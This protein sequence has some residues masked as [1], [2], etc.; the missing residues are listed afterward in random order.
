MI[1]T[2]GA[3]LLSNVTVTLPDEIQVRGAE[4]TL[5][6]IATIDGED[7]AAVARLKEYSLGYA[8]SPGYSRVVQRWKLEQGVQREFPGVQIDFEGKA[9]CRIWPSVT[10]IPKAELETAAHD[11][12][13]AVFEGADVEIHL[14]AELHDETVPVGLQSRALVAEPTTTAIKPGT[15]AVPVKVL[16]DGMPYRTVWTSFRVDLYGVV[17]V[18]NRDVPAGGEIQLSDVVMQRAPIDTAA[19]L[20]PLDGSKLTG[21]KARRLLRAGM[22]VGE[23]D[24]IRRLAVSRGETVT[25]VVNN[26]LVK[27]CTEVVALRDGYVGDLIPVQTFGRGKELTAKAVHIGQLELNLNRTN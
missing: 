5:G 18:L 11:A 23:A 8:P 6:E 21:A 19:S 22:P 16:I 7:L 9:A 27:V 15:W 20:R 4:M 25:L 14:A 24:V 1:T 26:G 10:K 13:V 3:L 17:P 12:L 2:L